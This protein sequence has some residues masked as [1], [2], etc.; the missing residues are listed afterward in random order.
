[1]KNGWMRGARVD[2]VEA[3]VRHYIRAVASDAINAGIFCPRLGRPC[4]RAFA[5]LC[6]QSFPL[7]HNIHAEDRIY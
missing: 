2:R 1:M 5:L 7:L 6:P 4:I 3:E